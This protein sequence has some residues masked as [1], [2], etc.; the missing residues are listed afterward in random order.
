MVGRVTTARIASA[1]GGSFFDRFTEG[2]AYFG[3]ISRI[4]LDSLAVI[5]SP[6]DHGEA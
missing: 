2:F 4:S 3:G 6:D 1:S 5:D